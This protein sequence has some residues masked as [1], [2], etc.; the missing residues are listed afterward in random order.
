ML[1]RV[2]TVLILKNG[3]R[4][5]SKVAECL[6]VLKSQIGNHEMEGLP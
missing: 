3:Y 6:E 5:D 4:E 1:T 2:I